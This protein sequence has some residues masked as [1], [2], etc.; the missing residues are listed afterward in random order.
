VERFLFSSGRF[1]FF[2]RV[3]QTFPE[4]TRPP[5]TKLFIDESYADPRVFFRGPDGRTKGTQFCVLAQEQT[6]Q[7]SVWDWCQGLEG[8]KDSV[9]G[10]LAFLP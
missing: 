5:F 4:E 3:K 9:P 1:S 8:V 10:N 7:S 2:Q 6:W